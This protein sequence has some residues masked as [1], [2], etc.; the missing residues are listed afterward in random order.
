MWQRSD[1][2]AVR[3]NVVNDFMKE[4]SENLTLR[5]GQQI[6]ISAVSHLTMHSTT[7]Y[8]VDALQVLR[9]INPSVFRSQEFIAVVVDDVLSA[10]LSQVD[11][12]SIER[13]VKGCGRGRID[14]S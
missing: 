8:I 6:T 10:G 14:T 4:V 3:S 12:R 7:S 1:G 2:E 13:S 5:L 9:T 11:K